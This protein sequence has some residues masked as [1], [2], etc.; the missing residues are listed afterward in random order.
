M[1]CPMCGVQM[2]LAEREGVEIDFCSQCRGVWLDKG[3]L[4]IIIAAALVRQGNS[5]KK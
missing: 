2:K 4:E 1:N 3:E 5:L